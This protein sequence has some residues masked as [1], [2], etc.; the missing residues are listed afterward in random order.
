MT[1]T[2]NEELIALA[3]RL[4]A[5]VREVRTMTFVHVLGHSNDPGNERADELVQWGKA[6]QYNPPMDKKWVNGLSFDFDA[7]NAAH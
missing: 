3:R 6:D 7:F 1:I 5:A 2:A 4:L